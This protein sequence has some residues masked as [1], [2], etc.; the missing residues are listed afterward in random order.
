MKKSKSSQIK[1]EKMPIV[2]SDG[3][4]YVLSVFSDAVYKFAADGRY[5][6]SFGRGA[7]ELDDL[8]NA[9]AFAVDNMGNVYI[10]ESGQIHFFLPDGR[11]VRRFNAD[12]LPIEAPEATNIWNTGAITSGRWSSN[13]L[14]A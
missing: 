6:M 7:S 10:A 9:D 12:S 4:V 2:D 3:N 5:V 1:L 13:P 8:D 14:A 11:F